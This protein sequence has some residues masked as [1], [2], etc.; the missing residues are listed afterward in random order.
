MPFG[1]FWP[2]PPGN[3]GHAVP[4]GSS[5]PKG[6]LPQL[7]LGTAAAQVLS[8]GPGASHWPLATTFLG[9]A[10]GCRPQWPVLLLC[11]LGEAESPSPPWRPAVPALPTSI[12]GEGPV[13]D[14]LARLQAVHQRP[15]AAGAAEE[16]VAAGAQ[17]AQ[18]LHAPFL[19]APVL[20]PHLPGGRSRETTAGQTRSPA[21]P[22]R[23]DRTG[24]ARGGGAQRGGSSPTRA[25][26]SRA[27]QRERPGG[28]RCLLRPGRTDSGAPT[29]RGAPV[30]S[31]TAGRLVAAWLPGE[32]AP[33]PTLPSPSAR[34]SRRA[35]GPPS[36]P[37]AGAGRSSLLPKPTPPL[38]KA[39]SAFLR[40]RHPPKDWTACLGRPSSANCRAAPRWPRLQRG[41]RRSRP[42]RQEEAAWEG[43]THTTQSFA[44][45]PGSWTPAMQNPIQIRI[46]TPPDTQRNQSRR[47]RCPDFRGFLQDR[48]ASP[49]RRHP[50]PPKE[51]PGDLSA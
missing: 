32:G 42:P 7:C 38:R 2:P 5:L 19:R 28:G 44:A 35:P 11:F 23:H 27:E 33:A 41:R 29:K 10:L 9:K 25:E 3:V 4:T 50:L 22:H 51:A 47:L 37:P 46:Q 8:T 49:A 15:H 20:E 36:C 39:P 14:E 18:L 30:Q 6:F 26:Q 1:G 31:A 24:Q 43:H 45:G 34:S 13:G 12:E 21:P 40:S 16:S 17:R 48:R